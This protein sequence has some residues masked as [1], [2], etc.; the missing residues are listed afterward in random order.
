MINKELFMPQIKNDIILN[1]TPQIKKDLLN[2]ALNKENVENK[3]LT[4]NKNS[5]I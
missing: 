2:S 4:N 5:D 1:Q 3:N